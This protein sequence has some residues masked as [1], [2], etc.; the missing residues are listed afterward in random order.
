MSQSRNVCMDG[1]ERGEN[2]TN[3]LISY[4]SWDRIYGTSIYLFRISIN[5]YVSWSVT[6]KD[7]TGIYQLSLYLDDQLNV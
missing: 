4:L 5:L 1:Y 3:A 6:Y 7:N 2:E